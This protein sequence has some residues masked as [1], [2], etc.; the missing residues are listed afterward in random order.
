VRRCKLIVVKLERFT[1]ALVMPRSE[2][3]VGR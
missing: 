1:T 2:E 3:A